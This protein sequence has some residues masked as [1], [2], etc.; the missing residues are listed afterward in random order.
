M[1]KQGNLDNVVTYE[2]I[3][4]TFEDIQ[5]IDPHYITLGST[6][7]VINGESGGLEVY[8]A[9]SNKEWQSI[10]ISSESSEDIG[11]GIHIC[12]NNEYDSTTGEPIVEDPIENQFYLV[13]SSSSDSSNL[14]DE[15]IYINENWEK[16]GSGGEIII[17]SQLSTTSANPVQNKVIAT[18]LNLKQNTLTFDSSPTSGSSNPVT[19]GGVYAALTGKEATSN[20]VTTITSVSTDT[21]YPSAAAVWTLFNSIINADATSY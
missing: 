13:P 21:Q 7:V 17:D 5:S 11:I 3:C 9:D 12:G 14:F 2:H 15:W 20:K 4:D 19:S 1:T 10:S 18:A 16:F 8:M 6:C